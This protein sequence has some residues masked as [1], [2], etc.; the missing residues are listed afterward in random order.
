[1][2]RTLDLSLLLAGLAALLLCGCATPN[3]MA[4]NATSSVVDTSKKSVLLLSLDV[5]RT[6]GSIF[7]PR[8]STIFFEKPDAKQASDRQNFLL[9]SDATIE[10]ATEKRTRYL[11]SMALEPGPYK[12]ESIYGLASLFPFLAQFSV[13]LHMDYSVPPGAI[14]YIGRITARL[15]PRTGSEFRA[16]PLLPLL[17]QAITGMSGGTFDVERVDASAEDLAAFR[18]RYAVL[19]DARIETVLL[20]EFDRAKVQR[21]WDGTD[22]SR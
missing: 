6:D 19:K 3:K 5:Y 8:P 13:P 9:E 21:I 14:V 10:L 7:K 4:L 15:R 16:G 11:A 22:K 2:K 20:P 18:S 12:L 1:M 17:D